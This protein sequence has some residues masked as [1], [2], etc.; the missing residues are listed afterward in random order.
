M[1]DPSD[2]TKDEE[3]QTT[4]VTDTNDA[5]EA[6]K[7]DEERNNETG[8]DQAMESTT[9]TAVV[10]ESSVDSMTDTKPEAMEV[11]EKK[12]DGDN[13]ESMDDAEDEEENTNDNKNKNKNNNGNNAHKD[14]KK[15]NKNNNSDDNGNNKHTTTTT[16]SKNNG[17][18]SRKGFNTGGKAETTKQ[19]QPQT[20][21]PTNGGSS[22][23]AGP[24]AAAP[25]PPPVLK[26]TLSYNV[27]N[28]R[29]MI[30][31][32][33]NYENSSTFPPQRFELLRSLEKDD[34]LTDLTQDGEF[35]G[36]FSLAYF[37]TTSKGKQKERSK[38]ISES[39]VK[40]KFTPIEGKEGDF[41][42]DGEGTNQFGI[43]NINGTAT[44]SE[45]EGDPTYDIVLRK[46]YKPAS[47]I[48]GG[49][50]VA[51]A[52]GGAAAFG[53]AGGGPEEKEAKKQ[54]YWWIGWCH[55]GSCRC[56]P[57]SASSTS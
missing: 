33:W 41:D 30:R 7:D 35:H 38:V 10:A 16:G 54:C 45:H 3:N 48:G 57:R 6:M 12:D 4:T 56:R 32:M 8:A 18:G 9:G 31:G 26:G 36:S 29:H 25:P 24:P 15:D 27:E 21:T 5:K 40:I 39:G 13:D 47:Q 53:A 23:S 20:A 1:H 34:D 43:F 19:G 50:A 28:R 37:H 49:G 44:P 2:A 55:N 11:D 52:G 22:A 17:Q 14:E 42:V 46:R 51:A